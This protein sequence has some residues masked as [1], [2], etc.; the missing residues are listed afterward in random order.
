MKTK[1]YKRL[2]CFYGISMSILTVLRIVFIGVHHK[3]GLGFL[4]I[5]KALGIGLVIDS[6]VMSCCIVA[7]FLLGLLVS[8]INEKAGNKTLTVTLTLAL[9]SVTVINVV[10]LFYFK[11]YNTRLSYS[12][13]R[14]FF[15]N[16]GENFKMLWNSFPLFWVILGILVML[17][18]TWLLVERLFRDTKIR[19]KWTAI[20][21]VVLTFV[22]LSFLYYGPPFWR[23]TTFSTE[24]MLNQAA[25]NGA[26]TLAKSYSVMSKSHSDLFPFDEQEVLANM[27]HN[28]EFI[29]SENET[30]VT[31]RVPTLRKF[32][33]PIEVETPKN[34]VIIISE[35]FSATLTGVIGQ[36]ERSYSPYFDSISK[37]GVLF[38]H[39]FSNGPRTQHGLVS[40]LSGFPSV[41]GSSLIRRRET[42]SFFTLAD[43]LRPEGYVT[44]FIHG[45]DVDYDDMSDYLCQGNFQ[46]IYDV[47]DFE[48][49]RFKNDWGVC[50]ED[51]F[52]FAFK[53]ITET[54]QPHLTVI[55]TMSN[56]LPF[57]IPPYFSE[58]H[59]E[60]TEFK[61]SKASYYY[62]EYA[63]GTFIDKMKT[64]PD[65]DNTLILRIAD[66]G[67]V[68]SE[69]DHQF[70]L[71]HIPALLLNGSRHDTVFD[72]VCSQMDFAPTLLSEIGFKGAFP[73]IG[74]NL[75][76]ESYRPFATMNSYNDLHLWMQN[77]KVIAWD[78]MNDQSACYRMD[79]LFLL[80]PSEQSFDEE[81]NDMKTYLAF[82]SFIYQKGLYY[83]TNDVQK[84]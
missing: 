61:E 26:Y 49:W 25:S 8:L 81:L 18:L 28:L 72:E 5:L 43:A 27:E 64:L 38:T 55:L 35:S 60:V 30:T 3:A 75:F 6:S 59:P 71:F 47:D 57:D 13:V 70:R 2:L 16:F 10:D 74:R 65:Y 19:E 23:L 11:Y 51:L 34:I 69:A 12:L 80:E 82:L 62:S 33:Q 54:Q 79:D 17:I 1:L 36:D 41:I 56:H 52:D 53:K 9:I 22:V 83:I 58:A 39:C 76:D 31:S 20:P 63:F 37:E 77:G 21:T 32:N 44:S 29:R 7:C 84:D 40:V 42:N 14:Y 4:D 15:E 66:H 46:H 50:D 78:M 68:Y 73:C 48:T 45:G 24:V 67:E